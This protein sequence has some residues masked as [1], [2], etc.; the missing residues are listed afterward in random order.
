LC[1]AAA[2]GFVALTPALAMPVE[3]DFEK[4]AGA[5]AEGTLDINEVLD[6]ASQMDVRLTKQI[7]LLQKQINDLRAEVD[8]LRQDAETR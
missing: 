5:T 4:V 2:I 7:M 8:R 6:N 3:S 1:R